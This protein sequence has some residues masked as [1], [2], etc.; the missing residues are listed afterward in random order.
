LRPG[1]RLLAELAAPSPGCRTRFVEVWSDLDQ[2]VIPR[3]NARL[4]HPDLEVH[5]IAGH[6]V[7][8][9]RCRLMVVQEVCTACSV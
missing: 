3:E 8:I 5:E 7:G 6:G 4:H 9:G 1:G 2:V